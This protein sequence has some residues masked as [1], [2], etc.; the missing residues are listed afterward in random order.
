MQKRI[1]IK[2]LFSYLA[3]TGIGSALGFVPDIIRILRKYNLYWYLDEY[4]ANCVFPSK[5][6]WRKIVVDSLNTYEN[7]RWKDEMLKKPILA[8]LWRMH[9]GL[10]PIMLWEVAKRNPKCRAPI[11]HLVNLLCGN[12]PQTFVNATDEYVCLLC[13]RNF[14]EVSYHFIVECPLTTQARDEL[15]NSL[16]DELPIEIACCLN[17][18][19]DADVYDIL[20]SGNHVS[21]RNDKN[22]LD[23]FVILS[24]CSVLNI[25]SQVN[26]LLDGL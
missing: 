11:A 19:D 13:K 3:E 5:S 17:N 18:L 14:H 6:E 9:Q 1:F 25:I 8:R 24:A 2:R 16:T 21:I 12:V 22:I 26:D 23:T 4:L 20:L 10:K 15:W 7:E